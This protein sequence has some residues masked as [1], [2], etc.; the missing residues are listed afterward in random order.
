MKKEMTAE[1]RESFEKFWRSYPRKI[2]KG[3]AR[4][5][6]A[7]A[8]RIAAADGI[9]AARERQSGA[10]VFGEMKFI[11]AP[12]TWLNQERWEDE[13]G[14]EA[15]AG[16]AGALAV[17]WRAAA[18]RGDDIGKAQVRADARR[19]GVSMEVVFEAARG[20]RAAE[21]G[22]AKPEMCALILGACVIGSLA[23]GALLGALMLLE[24]IG[25]AP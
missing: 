14:A 20:L 7:A 16:A 18:K 2:G 25:G 5:A 17:A 12:A 10:G 23:A 4:R 22:A 6:W 8:L 11:P 24:W 19:L 1:Q 21:E 3:A 9:V 15:A 13:V